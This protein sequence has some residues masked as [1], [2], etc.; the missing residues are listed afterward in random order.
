[1]LVL[2]HSQMGGFWPELNRQPFSS[3]KAHDPM[4]LLSSSLRTSH[5]ELSESTL[6]HSGFLFSS[7]ELA[8]EYGGDH[9]PSPSNWMFS[10]S[11]RTQGQDMPKKP[12][13]LLPSLAE[14]TTSGEASNDER[15]SVGELIIDQVYCELGY[16]YKNNK[17][18]MKLR[19]CLALLVRIIMR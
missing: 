10:Q 1:M 17:C 6:L 18:R 5:S 19:K 8:L 13:R 2:Y 11:R 16:Y 14:L 4:G 7:L 3:L 15:D 9:A 12:P